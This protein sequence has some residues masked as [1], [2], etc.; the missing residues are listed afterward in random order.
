[1]FSITLIRSSHSPVV[2]P[3]LPGTW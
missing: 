1:M 3:G 2:I